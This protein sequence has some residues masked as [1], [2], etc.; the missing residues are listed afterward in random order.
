M[1]DGP[2]YL[3]GTYLIPIHHDTKVHYFK[4]LRWSVS[5]SGMYRVSSTY[6]HLGSLDLRMRNTQTKVFFG[7]QRPHKDVSSK[8]ERPVIFY[9]PSNYFLLPNY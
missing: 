3:I 5:L 6:S 7:G 9:G 8:T 4:M 2:T 1:A